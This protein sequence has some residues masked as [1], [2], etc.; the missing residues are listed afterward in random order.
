M[1]GESVSHRKAQVMVGAFLALLTA[2]FLYAWRGPAIKP[3]QRLNLILLS[4]DT[5]RADRLGAY[6]YKRDTTPAI[7]RFA[8]QSVVFEQ[9]VAASSWTIPSHVSLF[10][11]LYPS[12]HSVTSTSRK[13]P[14]EIPTLTEI[15]KKEG[16]RTFAFTGGGNMDSR[17]GFGRGFEMYTVREHEQGGKLKGLASSIAR[18]E[19]SLRSVSA[20]QPYFLFLHTYDVHCPYEAPAPYGH[21]FHSST[22]E[23]VE[24][25]RC[26]KGIYGFNTGLRPAQAQFV[27]DRYDG[28]I[29]VFGM[30]IVIAG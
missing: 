22:A 7:D 25:N 23:P 2:L 18:A 6:G 19:E 27:S 16:Y 17:I 21:M 3:K 5:L 10:T 30:R 28:S 29:Q 15:L 1:V 13:I 26:G 14:Q 20:D 24:G 8:K 11:G 12:S 4:I 9:T